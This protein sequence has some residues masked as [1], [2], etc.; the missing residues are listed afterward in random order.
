MLR[1]LFFII[2]IIF[3]SSISFGKTLEIEMLNKLG[4]EKMVY[5][6]K[7]AKVD[8]N[9]K[10]IWKHVSKG[11]NVEFIGMPKGVK[12]YKSK[13]NKKAEYEFKIPGIYLYQCTPHKAMGMIGIVLVGGDKSNLEEI[14]KVKLYGKS[15]KVFKNLLKDL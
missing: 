1:K 2:C 9:D 3:Y 4:K 12:K 11:H 7:V 15:K 13:I 10:I 14:K 6:I 5:S 8:Q